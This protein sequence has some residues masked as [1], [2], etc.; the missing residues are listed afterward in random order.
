MKT[1]CIVVVSLLILFVAVANYAVPIGYYPGLEKL[2]NTA[3]AIVILR[4]DC[5]LTDFAS[6]TGYSTHECYIYQ[7]LTQLPQMAM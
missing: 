3:D 4:I 5:H 7:T 2:I 1:K 6:P